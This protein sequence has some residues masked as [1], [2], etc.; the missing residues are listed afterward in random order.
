MEINSVIQY[1]EFITESVTRM[2]SSLRRQL[3]YQCNEQF[4]RENG[5]LFKPKPLLSYIKKGRTHE[6]FMNAYHCAERHNLLYVEGYAHSVIPTM[7][8]WIADETG[9]AFDPTWKKMGEEYFG[10]VFPL[11][12]V[13]KIIFARECYGVIDSWELGFPLLTGEHEYPITEETLRKEV[14]KLL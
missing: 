7:H 2:N 11:E 13:N 10:V 6:C 3:K 14:S 12:Y 9:N 5:Q 1:L 4:V 8:A